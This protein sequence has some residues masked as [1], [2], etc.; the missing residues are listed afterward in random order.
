MAISRHFRKLDSYKMELCNFLNE[1]NNNAFIKCDYKQII[2]N[3]KHFIKAI[4]SKKGIAYTLIDFNT[5]L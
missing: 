2:L 1:K 4:V 3:Y 5:Q